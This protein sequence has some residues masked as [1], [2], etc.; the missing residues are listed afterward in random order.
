TSRDVLVVDEAGMIGTR[1]LQRVLAEASD[2][3]AKV[4][5][6]G[7]TQQLQAIEAGAAFRL[8]A[9]RHG[10]AELSEVRRQSEEWMRQ[11]TRDFATGK[12]GEALAAYSN[13]GMVHPAA[14]RDEARTA[15]IDRWDAE[16]RADPA[17]SR[18]ILTHTNKE[19]QMLNEA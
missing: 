17:A 13:K 19:V 7:D 6:V 3:G 2:A 14:T 5:M 1:Q 16:R 4:V 10:A 18:M 15:L 11:A 8:L 9:E 12:S